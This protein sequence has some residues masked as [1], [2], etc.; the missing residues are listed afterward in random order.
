MGLFTW[1]DDVCKQFQP[2]SEIT[3]PRSG[4]DITHAQALIR[5]FRVPERKDRKTP[6]ERVDGY[7]RM[8]SVPPRDP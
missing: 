6:S 7:E 2:V 3:G 4:P 5:E 8:D 1:A